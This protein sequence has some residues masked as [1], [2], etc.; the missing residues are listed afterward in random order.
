MGLVRDWTVSPKMA[1]RVIINDDFFE[2]GGGG[3]GGGGGGGE[4]D[5]VTAYHS[6]DSMNVYCR[7]KCWTS[8]SLHVICNTGL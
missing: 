3:V 5:S 2:E 6:Y 8:S 1:S 7:V 4:V